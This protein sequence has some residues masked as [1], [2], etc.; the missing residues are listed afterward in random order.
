MTN[1]QTAS[2]PK[3]NS[4][5][6]VHFTD[7]EGRPIRMA[8]LVSEDMKN[9]LKWMRIGSLD[10]LLMAEPPVSNEALWNEIVALRE[11]V[12]SLAPDA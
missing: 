10:A 1:Q 4:I 9:F 6:N 8:C 5:W 11:K 7:S 2:P 3:T 12:C